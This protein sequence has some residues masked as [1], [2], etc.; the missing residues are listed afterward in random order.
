MQKIRLDGLD[1]IAEVEWTALPSDLSEKKA[2]SEYMSKNK[3]RRGL[4]IRHR[5]ITVVGRADKKT[6][7][8]PSAAALL[9]FASQKAM[10]DHGVASSDETNED[11]NWIVVEALES[12]ED[13]FWMGAVKNGVPVPGSDIVGT[14]NE[15]IEETLSLVSTSA[16]FTVFTLDK[17][18][19]YNV[20]SQVNSVVDKRFAEI[21]R[22]VP[23]K[24]AQLNLF[25]IAAI[26]AIVVVVLA[27]VLIGS[28]MAYS[29]WDEKQKAEAA[30]KAAAAQKKAQALQQA[31]DEK[32][33]EAEI[34]R[35]VLKGLDEGMSEVEKSLQAASPQDAMIAW[36]DLIYGVDMDQASW[37]MQGIACLLEQSV[38]KCT[39]S[40]NRGPMGV[41]KIL[42]D[43]F[44]E[45]EIDGDTASYVIEGSPLNQ[46][47]INMQVVGSSIDF[48]KIILSNLQMLRNVE[49]AHTV[50][51]SK[52]VTKEVKIPA[53]ATVLDK[54]AKAATADVAQ[55]ASPVKPIN[56]QLGFGSGNVAINGRF[57][58]QIAGV[59]RTV[60]STSV[61]A[62]DMTV[63]I[64]EDG[65]ANWSV[66]VEYLVR[67]LPQPV[68]PVV[69]IGEQ[70]I[71][72]KLPDKYIS[73]VP[74]DGEEVKES[75]V[76]STPPESSD[77]EGD[78]E[79]AKNEP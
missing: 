51:Q 1:V 35:L 43:R 72:V 76:T 30:K 8:V 75:N 32:Q 17:D 22:P 19:R 54:A 12:N 7:A 61:R 13:M 65:S 21:V 48:S 18:V 38:P 33:Y 9:A 64:S 6:G 2:L 27:M 44:P 69:R 5:G 45:A 74:T 31:A 58:W 77:V 66:N 59:S 41:N 39:V 36:R 46:R 47:N 3:A 4:I 68:I 42:L 56:I 50:S 16:S 20:L 24:K 73:A 79:K 10:E 29:K 52:E 63:T 15:V 70:S 55:G 14:K 28:W 25:S 49:I 57:L 26:L 11:H 37:K 23:P 71:V 40:L 53:K 62:K 34:R 78:A 60:D 67:T